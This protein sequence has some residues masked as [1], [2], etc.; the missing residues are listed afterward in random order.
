MSF[1]RARLSPQK[2]LEILKKVFEEGLEVVSVCRLYG[3]SRFSFYKWARVYKKVIS[4]KSQVISKE[5]IL[6]KLLEA[7]RPRGCGHFRSIKGKREKLVLEVVLKNPHWS[8]HQ[9]SKYLKSYKNGSYYISNH[10]VHN[11]LKK[12]LLNTENLRIEFTGKHP[13]RSVFSARFSDYEKYLV[14]QE[15]EKNGLTISRVCR[16]FHISRYTYY[17]WLKKY[18]EE[19]T[20][21]SLA[22]N[23]PR[24]EDHPRFVGDKIRKP[25]LDLVAANPE[26]S[27]HQLHRQLAGIS[28]HHAIQNLLLR[29]G[30]NT[31]DRR[32]AYAQ[33]LPADRQVKVA[34]QYVPEIPVYR[35]RHLIAHFATVPRLLF[36]NPKKGIWYLVFGILPLFVFFL[37]IRLLLGAG[38]GSSTLGMIFASVA[39]TFGLFF[40]I[41]SMK[42]Y[43]TVLM[44]LKLASS[45]SANPPVKTDAGN[46]STDGNTPGVEE[47]VSVAGEILARVSNFLHLEGVKAH[48]PGGLGSQRINPLLINLEKVELEGERPFVSIHV[49]LYNEKRVVERLIQSC[50]SQAWYTP[51]NKPGLEESYKPG[52]R[53]G[54]RRANY[55]VILVDD[56]TDETTEIAKQSLIDNG[57]QQSSACL[58][59]RQV[60][61]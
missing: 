33:S 15:A 19:R 59:A 14:L 11:I 35:L 55:E 51:G 18:Q 31:Y 44:V 9:I 2:K 43:I 49:A 42:Y 45:G 37:W 39:L 58:P 3:I 27:V 34:P 36:A 47:P 50:T 4:D 28:G 60:P 29:E 46:S 56:S 38:P 21:A 22:H 25:V 10:G 8:S 48:L 26:Y 23:R 61:G 53:E 16:K 30:L 17:A 5:K 12:H 52:L 7:K 32:L 13:V 41:Y 20:I 57:W 1:S 6:L 24:G 40:F 54:A